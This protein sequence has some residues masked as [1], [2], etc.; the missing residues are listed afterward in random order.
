[1]E[2][3]DTPADGVIIAKIPVSVKLH[4]GIEQTV[5]IIFTHR[6][7]LGSCQV[8]A[9]PC[10]LVFGM[11]CG[12]LIRRLVLSL[13]LYR[14]AHILQRRVA[15]GG[16]DPVKIQDMAEFFFQVPALYDTIHKTVI[17]QKF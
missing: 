16:A 5:N 17:Q 4:K 12:H 11:F 6:T 1:M 8:Y 2:Q 3:G 9:L 10:R 7:S 13:L 14:L 15:C